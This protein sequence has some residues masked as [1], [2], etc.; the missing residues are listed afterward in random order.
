MADQNPLR[1]YQQIEQSADYYDP[2]LYY[3][4]LTQ[5]SSIEFSPDQLT[6]DFIPL[7]TAPAT[8]DSSLKLFAIGLIPPSAEVT[9]RRLDRSASIRGLSNEAVAD[10]LNLSVNQANAGAAGT[11]PQGPTTANSSDFWNQYV[12]MCNRLGCDALE[13]GRVLYSESGFMPSAQYP[14]AKIQEQTG[15][16]AIA[17]GLNQL[18]HDTAR[19][20]GMSEEEWQNYQ[21][22]SQTDQL[23]WVEKYFS[24]GRARGKTAGQI[25]AVNFG[26]N[27]NP[28]GSMYDGSI[29]SQKE[30]YRLNKQLDKD[31]KGYITQADLEASMRQLPPHIRSKIESAQS[32]L[33]MSTRAP[34]APTVPVDGSTSWAANGSKSG[35]DANRQITQG[36]KTD[37]N[38][39]QLGRQFAEAQAR[40]AGIVAAEIALMAS[41]PPLRMLVNPQSF[42][43]NN[44]KIM[45]DGNRSRTGP[46]T[47]VWGDGQDT[48]EASGKIGA[49]YCAD[50][51]GFSGPNI[52][53]SGGPGLTRTA[54]SFSAAYQNFMSLYQIYRNNAGIHVYDTVD[55]LASQK[56]NLVL[57]GSVYI[58]FDH[59]LYVGSFDSFSVTETDTAP[60]TLEYSYQFTVRAAFLL[61]QPP[62]PR[63]SYGGTGQPAPPSTIQVPREAPT[64]RPDQQVPNAPTSLA[65]VPNRTGRSPGII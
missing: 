45:N 31:N 65:D 57:S 9:G 3:S 30:A 2:G 34:Q 13:M 27:N 44:E 49:F 35:S 5:N 54:R 21:N 29:P 25:Y 53:E 47:E 33:G 20:L 61:D 55:S 19:G 8:A 12:A 39:T 37:L 62:D 28:N 58:Y 22:Q 14:N 23:K 38:S 6:Q 41:I 48:I 4:R 52:T 32:A 56:T 36:S 15:Q 40:M 18:T 64:P 42:K 7:S 59:T 17:K 51:G 10:S 43:I 26:N 63:R 11:V 50:V 1:I 46:I 60:F 24:G 16:K